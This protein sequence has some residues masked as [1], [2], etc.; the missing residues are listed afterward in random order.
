M[1]KKKIPGL[2]LRNGVWIVDKKVFGRRICESTGTSSFD[3]AQK[4]LVHR[5]EELREAVVYGVRPKRTFRQAATKYLVEKRDKA[6][7]NRDAYMLELLVKYIGDLDL[8]AIHMGTLQPFILARQKEGVKTRTINYALQVIRHLL[9]LAVGEWLDEHGLTW[10]AHVP[11]I[12]LLTER[13]KRKPY[14][15]SWEEQRL[16]FQVLPDH[17]V[18]MAL[19]AVNTG[20]RDQEI[21]R[22]R[23]EWETRLDEQKSV[24]IIPGQLVKNRDDRLVVLNRVAQSVIESVRGK[25]ADYVFTYKGEPISR[26]SNSAWDRARER[27]ELSVRPHDL[28]HTFGRRLRA[29]GVSFEDRQD[30][31]GHRSGRI[32]TH[33]SV[34]EIHNLIDA[35]NKACDGHSSTPVTLLKVCSVTPLKMANTEERCINASQ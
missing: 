19:F 15:L 4:F 25:N 21:C 26:M 33:Y 35:A 16:L 30:L 28:K 20:C 7:I 27:V 24:F 18:K 10:L 11:K 2:Q 8:D 12:K 29:A 3:E 6:S 23:W 5:I 17:L 22:L 9:N 14:P 34:A 13:D 31:L 32:T 1:G